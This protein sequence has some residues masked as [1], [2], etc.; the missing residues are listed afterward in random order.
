MGADTSGNDNHFATSN[1]VA[2]DV[3]VDTPTNNFFTMNALGTIGATNQQ[4]T[5]TDGMVNGNLE[6]VR[7]RS[8]GESDGEEGGQDEPSGSVGWSPVK[9]SSNSEHKAPRCAST[10]TTSPQ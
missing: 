5:N 1:H 10:C 7:T 3:V 6:V 8:G 4:Q 2:S 9:V